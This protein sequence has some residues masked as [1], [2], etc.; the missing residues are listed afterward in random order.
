MAQQVQTASAPAAEHTSSG[1]HLGSFL[2]WAVVF[3]DIGTS[4]YYTPGILWRQVTWQAGLFVLMTLVAFVL[5]VL[6]YAEVSVR[7]PEGGGVVTVAARGINPW[8]GAVG[9][10]FILVDYFL[11]AA[12]SSL[13]GLLY[14]DTIFRAITPYV[15]VLTIIV[16]LLLG[17]LNWWGIKE[18]ATVSAA[19][20]VAA[21]VSDLVILFV[22]F[23]SVPPATIVKVFEKI[24]SGQLGGVAI[25]TGFAGAFL[26]FS[27]LESISQLS[28][29]MK[30]PRS[31]TVTQA[32][33]LVALTVGITSPL[34]TIFSTVLLNSP[35]LLATTHVRLNVPVTPDTFISDLAGTYG[36]N[37]LLIATAIAAS[38]LLVFASNTAIIGAYHV[39]LALSRMRFFPSVVERTNKW[40]GTPHVSIALATFIPIGVLIAVRGQIDILGDMYAFG[41]LG[42]FALTCISID[43]IRFRERRGAEHIGAVTEVE[44]TRQGALGETSR[45]Q[46]LQDALAARLSAEQI[47]RLLILRQRAGQS[48]RPATLRVR[49]AWPDIKYYIG[50]LTTLLVSVA[51]L[52]NLVAKPLATLFG[53]ALTVLGVGVSVINYRSQQRVGRTPVFPMSILRRMPGSVLVALSSSDTHNR[54]VVRAAI[55]SAEGRPLVFLYLSKRIPE[56]PRLMQFGDPYLTDEKAKNVFTE[57]AQEARE[58]GAQANFVYRVGGPAQLID[59]WRIIRPEEIM[60]EATI[61]KKLSRD[62][63]PDYVRYTVVDGV[64]VAHYVRHH[65]PGVESLRASAADVAQ[66]ALPRGPRTSGRGP[67]GPQSPAPTGASGTSG[68]VGGAQ[69][70]SA[71]HPSEAPTGTRP[72]AHGTEVAGTLPGLPSSSEADEWIWTGTD[73]VRRTAENT[74]P[75]PDTTNSSATPGETTADRRSD[76]STDTTEAS[77]DE[78]ERGEAHRDEAEREPHGAT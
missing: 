58:A 74:Q 10:M 40:R 61:A 21:L 26:A 71:N 59:V 54:Q 68:P 25:L 2:C 23:I 17:L 46:V 30:L 5:L 73:L 35:D 8:V 32:L 9:G 76:A 7:F 28:P 12:I 4:V 65:I 14:F 1:G 27:G 47:Q 19:I 45:R 48:L 11:T 39:F 38:A 22:V 78:A 6:K 67:M 20:A 44:E 77:R 36:G 43:V 42:A 41:L 50:F 55:E 37:I 60:A 34:L 16:L 13:S 69:P 29:V 66:P 31:K 33:A 63:P 24:F 15:V 72:G 64:R 51:W 53:G 18:S 3:A 49:G 52:T 62:V 57:A 56:A 75:Q 70:P